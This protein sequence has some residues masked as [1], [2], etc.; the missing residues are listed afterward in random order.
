MLIS[1]YKFQV[2]LIGLAALALGACATSEESPIN[3]EPSEAFT[4]EDIFRHPETPVGCRKMFDSY[5]TSLHSPQARGN[6]SLGTGP[7]AEKVFQGRTPNDFSAAFY[8]YARAKIRAREAL[9]SDF[10]TALDS[11]DYFPKL[12][13]LLRRP[14][15]SKMSLQTRLNDQRSESETKQIWA[16]AFRE[17]ILRRMNAKRRGFHRLSEDDIPLELAVERLRVR[18]QFISEIASKIWKNDP[19]WKSVESNFEVLRR[20]F[21]KVIRNLEIPESVRAS[22]LERIASVRLAIPGTIPAAGESDC[23]ST[24]ANA[25]YYTHLN[26]ITVCAGDFNTEGVFQTVA[27][28][29]AHSLDVERSFYLAERDSEL[30]KAVI[31]LRGKV[32][33]KDAFTCE[34][35]NRF[36]S[37]FEGGL[38]SLKGYQP[39]VPDFQ[40]C[41]QKG[42]NLR[43]AMDAD[44]ERI[45]RTTINDQVSDLASSGV[46]LRITKEKV[47]LPNGRLAKNPNYMNPCGYNLWSKGEEAIDDES[48]LRLFFT[49]EYRCSAAD[50]KTRLALSIERAK[51]LGTRVKK[52]TLAMEGSFS[53]DPALVAEGFASSPAERFADVLGSYAFASYL[54]EVKNMWLRR[55]LY[56]ASSSWQCEQPSLDSLYPDERSAEQAFVFDSHSSGSQRKMENF[57]GPMRSVL[58]CQPDFTVSKCEL[59]TRSGAS[60][61][62]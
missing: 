58:D 9:P 6:I 39:D 42:P 16:T 40:R 8:L 15:K 34:D 1:Q 54:S 5:C 14:P 29:L 26:I 53:D 48:T 21:L 41:L 11:Q 49:A 37:S 17:T 7:K 24:Q 45:A 33:S 3:L 56:L 19:N 4:L 62:E 25:Y 23:S 44:L 43:V 38:R 27:H 46:F 52:A 51:E 30:G 55:H 2:L 35:W 36:K 10:R 13:R 28:E 31:D 32:C 59:K 20:H 60:S 47:P 22:W 50:P 61:S 12:A 18:T 57:S